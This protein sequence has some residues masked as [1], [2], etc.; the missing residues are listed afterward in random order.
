M[1]SLVL[2]T[3]AFAPV[4]AIGLSIYFKDKY[5]REPIGLVSFFMDFVSTQAA[6]TLFT[7]LMII[8][9]FSFHDTELA[10]PSK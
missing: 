4:A 10:E 5:E 3:L 7:E 1:N 2:L 6:A 9:G 8:F